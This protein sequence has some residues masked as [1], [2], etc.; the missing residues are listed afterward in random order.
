MINV[1]YCMIDLLTVVTEGK[2]CQCINADE[3]K[4]QNLGNI[5]EYENIIEMINEIVRKN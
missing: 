2:C 3:N 5:Y 1:I 4:S